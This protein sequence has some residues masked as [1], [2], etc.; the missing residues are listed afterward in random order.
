MP[1]G[2]R[3]DL[4]GHLALVDAL[5]GHLARA[6]R[7]AEMSLALADGKRSTAVCHGEAAAH[8]A[9][10]A[11][12]LE[13]CHPREARHH[14]AV[15]MSSP[16]LCGHPLCQALSEMVAAGADRA[17][18]DL[19]SA[20]TRLGAGAERL[21]SS[22]PWLAD[23][24]RLEA[25]RLGL[26]VGR[27]QVAL[28]VLDG[29]GHPDE[30]HAAAVA[31]VVLAE[32]GQL[33]A[34]DDRLGRLHHRPGTL[35]SE[36]LALLAEG[37]RALQ[38]HETGRARAALDRSL[39]LAAPEGLRRPFRDGGPMVQRLLSADPVALREHGWLTSAGSATQRVLPVSSETT[40]PVPPLG[41]PQSTVVEELTAKELEVLRHLAE[42]L[43]TEEIAA[44]M[45]ISVNTV[46]THVR[47]ILRKLDVNR[48]NAAVR[49][50]R[51]L[52]LLGE[53]PSLPPVRAM[54]SS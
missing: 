41:A 46:R 42:L 12:A 38:H 34:V 32:R 48:R 5:E 29:V 51:E 13:R 39:R 15:A 24:M 28:S 18:G 11:V 50:A 1:S 6:S 16:A 45:F 33:S 37:S 31:A 17:G 9:L 27:P 44:T 2:V 10:G 14:V 30:P 21:T 8:L 36:V 35:Q 43:N 19:G 4:L 47:N 22:D 25:A 23:R 40:R 20:L 26:A 49:R 54:A 52:G 53:E 3:A 7:T